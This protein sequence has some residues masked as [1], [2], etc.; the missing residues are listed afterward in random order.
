MFGDAVEP[1]ALPVE[2][3]ALF[4]VDGHGPESKRQLHLV[5]DGALLR[6]LCP[7][8]VEMGVCLPLPEMGVLHPEGHFFSRPGGNVQAGRCFAAVQNGIPGR[9]PLPV[10]DPGPKPEDALGGRLQLD[11]AAAIIKK[12][13]VGF[14]GFHQ[15]DG[16]VDAAVVVKISGEGVDVAV[17]GV[18]GP[19]GEGVFPLF[20]RAA[21]FK[22]EGGI[23]A[24]VLPQQNAVEHHPA[25]PG[26]PLERKEIV[27]VLLGQNGK[28]GGIGA[29]ARLGGVVFVPD[30]GQLHR[31][32]GRAV[33]PGQRSV[34][35]FQPGKPP[36]QRIERS[37]CTHRKNSFIH[38]G[39]GT[40]AKRAGRR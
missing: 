30:V 18:V 23:A 5:A 8:G 19:D 15:A 26:H 36:I 1:Q 10:H 3:E 16:A 31:L 13:K 11:A 27:P 35:G 39:T 4:R 6:Q 28:D 7:Q 40:D 14:G 22:A 17:S 29:A 33:R 12:V 34:R 32:P 24:P 25:D 9:S 21:R 38:K 20:Q 37:N 2:G